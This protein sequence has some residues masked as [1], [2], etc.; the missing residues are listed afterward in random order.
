MIS[1]FLFHPKN[2]VIYLHRYKIFHLDFK[3]KLRIHRYYPFINYFCQCL[4]SILT[5]TLYAH[6]LFQ[7]YGFFSRPFTTYYSLIVS[8]VNEMIIQTAFFSLMILAIF[9][10]LKN[11]DVS[12]R[13]D[14]GLVII[15]SNLILLYWV[16][17]T[18]ILRPVFFWIY[19]DCRKRR[20]LNKVHNSAKSMT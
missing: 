4:L 19:E 6:P 13:M 15:F 7:I 3:S 20:G 17:G 16:I 11:Y 8:L 12:K 1:N 18:G 2:S 10:F 5:V 14:L 9:D